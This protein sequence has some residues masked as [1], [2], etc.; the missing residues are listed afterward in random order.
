MKFLSKELRWY[1]L[2]E[3]TEELNALFEMR[4]THVHKGVF[5]EV[6]LVKRDLEVL[7][8]KNQCPHQRKS[9]EGAVV[10]EDHIVCPFHRFH[11]SCETGQGHG[12][13]IDKYPLKTEDNQV[14]IGKEVWTFFS[15]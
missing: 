11:F 10:E 13:Y 12:L 6:L 5:G 1:L 8:F 4:N 14:F 7:A 3:S 2:F 15:K 9:L